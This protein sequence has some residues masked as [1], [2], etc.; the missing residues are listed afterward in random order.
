M[1]QQH[2][3]VTGL[4][5]PSHLD[6]SYIFVC[7]LTRHHSW[8]RS[9]TGLALPGKRVAY[10]TQQDSSYV[11]LPGRGIWPAWISSAGWNRGIQTGRDRKGVED[12]VHQSLL[13]RTD[14]WETWENAAENH[15][16]VSFTVHN[17]LQGNMKLLTPLPS[18]RNWELHS[19]ATVRHFRF[20]IIFWLHY[21]LKYSFLHFT[22][23]L[24]TE[25]RTPGVM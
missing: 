20:I 6:D 15:E 24:K 25:E 9:P 11:G 5:G 16:C 4:P 1:I 8:A 13:S 7:L 2:V 17:T 18:D 10:C 21:L 19:L 12:R 14:T 22:L 3:I 23:V